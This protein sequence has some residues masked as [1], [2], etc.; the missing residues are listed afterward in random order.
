MKQVISEEVKI[1]EEWFKEAK[2]MT[3]EKLPEFLRHLMEDYQHDYGTICHALS[4]GAI[5][6][7]WALDRHHNGGITGFQ[8]GFVMWDFVRNWSFSSNKCGLKIV[9]YDNLLYPQ[10]GYRFDKTMTK[11]IWESIQKQAKEK[12]EEYEKEVEQYKKRV[13]EYPAKFQEFLD[14]AS[15]YHKFNPDKPSYEENPNYYQEIH[16]GTSDEWEEFEKRKEAGVPMQPIEPCFCG[17]CDEVVVHWKKIANG[18]MPF[19]FRLE[20]K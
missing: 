3:L 9:D 7:A 1:H 12:I 13:N 19:G 2:E 10:Y 14:K 16:C 11:D 20:D 17:A 15:E 5:A 18:I 6:T 4:A 8:S